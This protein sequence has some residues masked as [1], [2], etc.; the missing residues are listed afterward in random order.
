MVGADNIQVGGV[1][2]GVPVTSTGVS[3]SVAGAAATGS[4]ATK[5][6]IEAGADPTKM[7]PPTAAGDS[8]GTVMVE[9]LCFEGE[10]NDCH[11]GGARVKAL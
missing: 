6:A 4:S 10:E 3:G 2:S 5:A 9:V 8:L 1:S 11:P 7:L